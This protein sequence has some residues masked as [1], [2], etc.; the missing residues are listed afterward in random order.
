MVASEMPRGGVLNSAA[1]N[2]YLVILMKSLT[3]LMTFA[4]LAMVSSS[5]LAQE[6]AVGGHGGFMA[7]C[8]ADIQTYCSSAQ[9]RDERRACVKANKDKFS[10]SCKSFMASHMRRWH[11][12]DQGADKGQGQ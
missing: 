3:V 10:D 2:L 8:G 12:H 5:S 6:A 7:A 4:A 1:G 11:D 9:N